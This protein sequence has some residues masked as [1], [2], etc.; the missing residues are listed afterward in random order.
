MSK[1]KTVPGTPSVSYC[2]ILLC[3]IDYYMRLSGK[4]PNKAR[5]PNLP[6]SQIVLFKGIIFGRLYLKKKRKI[7]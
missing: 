1:L 4:P 2:Y 7:S 3:A 6:M 5:V